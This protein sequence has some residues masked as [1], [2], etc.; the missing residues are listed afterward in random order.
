[1]IKIGVVNKIILLWGPSAHEKLLP[2]YAPDNEKLYLEE[3][4]GSGVHLTSC[5]DF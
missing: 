2:F 3:K 1:M 4:R 5:D